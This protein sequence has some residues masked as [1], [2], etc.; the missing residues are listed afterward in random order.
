M[1]EYDILFALGYDDPDSVI[2]AYIRYVANGGLSAYKTIFQWGKKA[3]EPVYVHFLN[4][5]FTAER[6]RPLLGL[7]DTEARVLYS[8]YSV[9]DINKLVESAGKS[10]NALA[11]KETVQSELKRIGVPA[12]FPTWR[13]YL[14]DI[15]WLV[16]Y[17][18]G[19]YST[20][21]EGLIPAL[22]LYRL[23]RD[24]VQRVLGPLMQ[25]LDVLE[26]STTLEERT[27][28]TGF[29]LKLNEIGDAQYTFVTHQ[30]TEQR[31]LLTNLIHNRVG[32]HL[33]RRWG[34]VPLLFYP[35]GVAYLA[36]QGRLPVLS[37]DDLDAIG[38]AVAGAAAGMSR[39]EF[40][41]FIRSGNQGIKVNK[42]CLELGVSFED[43]FAIVYNHVAA[44]VTGKRFRIEDMEAKARADLSAKYADEKYAAQNSLIQHLLDRTVLYPAS[45]AGMG[46]GELLR[47]YYIFLGD[48][49]AKQVGDPWQYLYAWLELTPEQTVLYD[50]L[51]PRY[52]RAYAVAGDLGLAIDLLYERSLEDG[53]QLMPDTGEEG[54]GDYAVLADYVART[55][56]FSFGGEREVD[57]GAAL[58]AYV[59]N[60]HRQCCYCGSEFPTQKWM[61]PVAP[62]NVTVQSFSN[63]LPGGWSQEPKKNVCDV[64]RLQF[65]LE[66]LTHQV[67]KG[68]KTMYLHLYPY[69]FYTDVFLRSLRDEVRE[70][71]AQD[72]TVVFPRSADAFRS[73]LADNRVEL[74]VAVR[75][76]DGKP[77]QNGIVL[78]RHAETIGNLLIFPLNCPGGNDSEQ[79]L[80]G[81]QNALL[82]QR[83]FGC[84]AVL[85]DSP[86]P[87]LGKDDFADLFVDNAPLGFEGLLPQDEFDRTALDRLWDDVLA[88]HR[89]RRA[90]YNPKREENPQLS[91][92]RAMADG[93]LRLF[94]EADRLVEHKA[95]QGRPDG[96]VR[97]WRGS[98]IARQIL[99]DLRKLAKGE[100]TMEQ[101]E[102]LARMA[103]AGRI[104]GRSLERNALLKPLDML[105][106]GLEKKP[107]AFG[108]DTLRAQLTEDIFRHL[109]AIAS[110]EYKPGR[111]KREKVKAYVDAFFDGLLGQAYRG[112]VTKLL[113]DSKP[114]RSAYLFYIREQ[115]PTKKKGA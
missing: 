91:L 75:R 114:L 45:Q 70:L 8:A 36:E 82:I 71:L 105:L 51:D 62:A 68:I 41:K 6:L 115:I 4:G 76:A 55:V 42:Q 1:A 40:A 52:Q 34:L 21:A 64:C 67:L 104:I 79:F 22:D 109:E 107:E 86:V 44:K 35:D 72:T 84:K 50:L 49:F 47:S 2:G 19:H 63:R 110:E 11:V 3:G 56:T 69:S 88:L 106:E 29:L 10:F 89:L 20:A 31:G 37:S 16:R 101:L 58:E 30:V 38:K 87:I 54:L 28:K 111:T 46:A 97:A 100:E 53:A 85:T 13:D 108:L 7:S 43:I 25:A 102:R 26:L 5:V 23:D 66:K 59:R 12:F 24:R 92:V 98:E 48:H 90:L 33:E 73:F 93:R 95:A 80:F 39:G 65:T 27:H 14:E 81:L 113:A 32:A 83:Y 57:F 74:P 60:N 18:S 61:A 112:N 99:P 17:H 78:P 96:K 9:H 94:F 103:W 15:T 77:Y